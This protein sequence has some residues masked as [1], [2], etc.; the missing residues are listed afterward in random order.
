MKLTN[1][2]KTK[3][4]YYD[5]IDLSRMP[6]AYALVQPRL[7]LGRVVHLVGTNGKGSTG[8]ILASL[9]KEAGYRVGHYSSP[10]ILR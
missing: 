9:L 10:H 5:K 2:L 1:F 4:L 6:R 8:R 7:K 3:P